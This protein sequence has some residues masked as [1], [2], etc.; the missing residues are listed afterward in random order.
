MT[1]FVLD[2]Q[3]GAS[4]S[5]SVH[6]VLAATRNASN[7][8]YWTTSRVLTHLGWDGR[9]KNM[10]PDAGLRVE[11][12]KWSAWF[13]EMSMDVHSHL[14][15]SVKALKARKQQVPDDAL[16][17]T[18]ISTF[19]LLYVLSVYAGR[20]GT[21]ERMHAAQRIIETVVRHC[22]DVSARSVLEST[23]EERDLCAQSIDDSNQ[24]VHLQAVCA[25]SDVEEGDRP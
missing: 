24:C 18:T 16:A 8:L 13:R 15:L 1:S 12:P 14:R 3:H 2:T 20:R 6:V 11:L 7:T 19:G 21:V 25:G 17:W 10:E 22:T 5:S 23:P 4:S 9:T